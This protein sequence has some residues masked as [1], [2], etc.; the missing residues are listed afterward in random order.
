MTSGCILV[1]DDD[2]RVARLV[3]STLKT[4]GYDVITVFSGTDA[5]DELDH[6]PVDLMVLDLNMP[7]MDGRTCFREARQHGYRGPVMLL[8]AEDVRTA[9]RELGADAAIRKPFD[10]EDLLEATHKLVGDEGSEANKPSSN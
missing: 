1:V 7:G 6:T 4:E 3:S 10:F 5:V 2:V 8:S 9:G